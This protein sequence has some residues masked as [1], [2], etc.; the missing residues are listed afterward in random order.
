MQKLP[1]LP[2]FSDPIVRDTQSGPVLQDAYY[3]F[4]K[5][6]FAVVVEQR[7]QI[8]TLRVALN[9]VRADPTTVFPDIPDF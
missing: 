3:A 6:L 2:N 4:L 9:E 7:D 1:T 5:Q 8:E